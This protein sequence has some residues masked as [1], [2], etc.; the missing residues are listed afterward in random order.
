[1]PCTVPGAFTG[2]FHFAFHA[3]Y[4]NYFM[5]ERRTQRGEAEDQRCC[6]LVGMN[7]ACMA[8]VKTKS[9]IWVGRGMI[10]GSQGLV[11]E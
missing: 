4:Q 9:P 10:L 11:E 6:V 3:I 7:L 5:W 1:M 8:Y 2:L